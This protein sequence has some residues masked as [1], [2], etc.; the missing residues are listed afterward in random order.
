MEEFSKEVWDTFSAID[1]APYTA[2]NNNVDYIT[3]SKVW[4][5]IMEHYPASSYEFKDNRMPTATD[6]GPCETVEVVCY[7]TIAK[8]DGADMKSITR[9][10]HLP[11]M[12]SYGQ[13]LAIEN[14]TSRQISDTRMR[15]LVKAAAMFGLGLTMWSGD[16]FKAVDKT[17]E[18]INKFAKLKSDYRMQLWKTAIAIKEAFKIDDRSTADEAWREC[19]EEE[20]THLWLAESTGGFFTMAE[21]EWLRSV[22]KPREE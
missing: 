19:T 11:V 22:H 1:V 16:E 21:K 13:F 17:Q 9:H 10:M 5:L 8:G 20:M 2:K 4:R 3:W 15:A 6:N 12:Q 18:R 14:P 7:L